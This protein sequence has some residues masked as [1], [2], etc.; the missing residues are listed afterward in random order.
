M[1]VLKGTVPIRSSSGR[2]QKAIA[3]DKAESYKI[4]NQLTVAP[5]K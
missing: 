5:A 2:R 3:R 4:V 1:V